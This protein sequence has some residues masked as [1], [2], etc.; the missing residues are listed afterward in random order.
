MPPHPG[1]LYDETISVLS[2]FA[3][4]TKNPPVYIIGQTMN[5]TSF[6]NRP[7]LSQSIKK[8]LEVKPKRKLKKKI[9]LGL[10][11]STHEYAVLWERSSFDMK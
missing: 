1:T 7:K 10:T 5:P 2:G 8:R 4:K 11:Y 3:E 6:S 9:N